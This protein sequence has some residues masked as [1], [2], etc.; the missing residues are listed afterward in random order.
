[1]SQITESYIFSKVLEEAR[2]YLESTKLLGTFH[3]EHLCWDI[4]L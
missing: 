3:I 4:K 1:M 2:Y